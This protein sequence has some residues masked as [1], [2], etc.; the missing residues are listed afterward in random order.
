MHI[1]FTNV[2]EDLG[3]HGIMCRPC[4]WKV[5]HCH[6][7]VKKRLNLRTEKKFAS[8]GDGLGELSISRVLLQY[9]TVVSYT[10]PHNVGE[11]L[12]EDDVLSQRVLLVK[13]T[14]QRY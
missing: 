5:P 9:A 8:V 1:H 7:V 6:N 4:L 13:C 10:L 3:E 11:A 2:G 14:T 12:G